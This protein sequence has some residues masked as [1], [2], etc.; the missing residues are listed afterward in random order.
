MEKLH[1]FTT[2]INNSELPTKLDYPHYYTPNTI[3]QIA[4]KELQE[5]LQ[6]QT[7]FIHNF[8]LNGKEKAIGKMFGV[9]VV[10]DVQENLGYLCAFSGKLADKTIHKHFVPPVYDIL[11]PNGFYLKTE[12]QLNNIN[13]EILSIENS[14]T[15][16]T[17]KQQYLTLK[18]EYDKLLVTERFKIKERRKQRRTLNEIDNQ[19]NINEEFYLKEYALYLNDKLAPCQKIYSQLQKKTT[20]LSKQR[21]ELSATL[22]QKIF[23][24]YRFLNAQQ[25]TQNLLQLFESNPT[26]IP[27]GAGDCCAPKLFQYAFQHQLKPIALAEFWWGAPLATS[28][29]KHLHYYPACT[30]KCKPILS[31][32][33]QGLPVAK[34][35]LLHSLNQPQY[36]DIFYEDESL[37]IVNKPEEFLSVAG[38]EIKHTI[39]SLAKKQ[40]PNATGPLIVHRLDMSTSG[41]LVIAKTKEAH[42]KLQKQFIEKTVQKRYVALLNGVI[43]QQKGTINLPLRVDLNDRPKQLVC[44]EHGKKAITYWEIIST[45]NSQTKIYFYPVT[46]RTHQLRVHAAHHLGLNTPIVGDDLYGTKANRL[47]LHAEYIRFVHPKTQLLVE[48][49]IPCPF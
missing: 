32:M 12:E 37:A 38:K 22:Q 8:G 33:L 26:L 24:H 15:Y 25:Q 48:F 17:A 20:K 47:H 1:R 44:Y 43:T 7:D 14:T 40:F 28:I 29:R 10:K 27:A 5:Y 6:K 9:L 18:N 49:T 36:L 31:F 41:V 42:Q 4:A 13:K 2:N 34:N 11:Q 39:E 46:G 16:L 23:E 30:G 35:S 21:A 45:D 19:K 3:A